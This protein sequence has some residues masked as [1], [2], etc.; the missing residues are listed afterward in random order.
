LKK[1]KQEYV[2]KR[3]EMEKRREEIKK[4]K[5]ELE[6]YNLSQTGAE[7][8]SSSSL[9]LAELSKT[10]Y[11]KIP[12]A[13]DDA[14]ERLDTDGALRPSIINVGKTW[15]K[16][17]QAGLMGAVSTRSLDVEQQKL[18]RNT[19]YDLL[20]ALTRSGGLEV[21]DAALHIVVSTTHCFARN[22]MD[23]L[24]KDNLNPIE[25]VEH[26]Q[27]IVASQ[28]FGKPASELLKKEEVER[29][30]RNSPALF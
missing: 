30:K 27:L 19:C 13:L 16:R 28:V 18:E 23:T 17:S 25:K 29:V 7:R 11:T 26:T 9:Q 20:D 8:P 5:A 3:A 1:I 22:L 4:E 14:L 12:T 10:D 6:Q 2:R 15:S 21:A 24:V